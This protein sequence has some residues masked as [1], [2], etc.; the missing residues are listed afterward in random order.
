MRFRLHRDI[1]G[2]ATALGLCIGT[3]GLSALPANAQGYM[4]VKLVSDIPGAKNTDPNLV[5]P[6][7]LSSLNGSPWWA[8]DNGSGLTTLYDGQG[9]I[10]TLV[11]TIP[12]SQSD[13]NQKGT[14][15]GTVANSST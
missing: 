12:P 8:S 4:K 1:R 10:Q 13:P 11:V 7:G 3:L 15:T 2:T 9:N 14:P 6:W 5:N